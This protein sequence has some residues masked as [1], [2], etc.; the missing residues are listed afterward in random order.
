MRRAAVLSLAVLCSAVTLGAQGGLRVDVADGVVS[1]E[2]DRVG[3]GSLLGELDAQA[4][5]RSTIPSG[6]QSRIVSVW[7][8]ELPLD[9]AI[10][11]LFEGLAL[12][13]AVVE[14]RQ[15]V[16]L[17]ASQAGSPTSGTESPVSPGPETAPANLPSGVGAFQ[18]PGAR[19]ETAAPVDTGGP[20][21][22]GGRGGRGGRGGQ[23]EPAVPGAQ[24]GRGGSTP[25]GLPPNSQPV[26]QPFPES[27]DVFGNTSPQILDLN[28]P[29]ELPGGP[30]GQ[31][32]PPPPS[33]PDVP[34]VLPPGP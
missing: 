4:G 24:P 33:P 29:R 16:V 26:P 10:R 34:P 5:T 12:D 7:F 11:K 32:A 15:I 22:Q 30:G 9:R 6:L 2:A 20:A 1:V 21:G 31:P 28:R 18:I 23:G 13:Y 19:G 25:F 17:A 27:P 8:R 14:G 3:L